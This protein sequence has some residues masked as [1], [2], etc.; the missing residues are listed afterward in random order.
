MKLFKKLR[1]QA[2]RRRVIR[3]FGSDVYIAA[4]SRFDCG[5]VQIGTGTR[6]NGPIVVRGDAG[7]LSLGNYCAIGEQ[8]RVIT[9]NHALDHMNLHLAL[10]AEI[11]GQAPLDVRLGVTV[12]HNCWIGDRV[13][14]L[15]GVE[16]GNGCIVGGGAVVTK[17]F[18]AYSVIGG[19]PARL[20]RKRFDDDVAA[21]LDALEWWTW[22]KHKMLQHRELFAS[23]LGDDSAET[24]HSLIDRAG[25]ADD[26]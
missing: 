16:I 23:P 26:E 19:N 17:G 8:V 2:E 11:T 14:L 3:G 9:M 15:P 21:A 20:I 7:G 18:P 12:G 1:Q 22:D 24:I 10:Q 5:P 25:K 4:G 6:I 13:L